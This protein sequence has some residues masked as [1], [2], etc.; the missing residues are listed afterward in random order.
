MLRVILQ[1]L[2]W[3]N[4][5]RNARYLWLSIAR[6]EIRFDGCPLI[7]R[8]VQW[9]I[10]SEA[11][12]HIGQDVE[13]MPYC[14]V[15]CTGRLE[16]GNRVLVGRMSMISALQEV[17]IGS[18]CLVGPMCY[19]TDNQHRYED[20]G[21]PIADQGWVTKPVVIGDDV[22]LGA[23][24]TVLAGVTIGDGAVIGANA[25]VSSDIPPNSVAVGVPA[26]V[27]RHRKVRAPKP[28]DSEVDSG[29]E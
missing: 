21:R 25:V 8:H 14:H 17:R 2:R 24:V 28:A 16:I 12:V 11:Q 29:G 15:L 27:I 6:P 26:R 10:A 4:I 5:V 20:A 19:I 23:K 18:R 7:G 1:N 22:W 3:R 13:I 9:N